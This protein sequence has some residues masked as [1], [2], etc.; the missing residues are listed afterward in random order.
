MTLLLD[1]PPGSVVSNYKQACRSSLLTRK[2]KQ[3]NKNQYNVSL[4]RQGHKVPRGGA[5]LRQEESPALTPTWSPEK[6][7]CPELG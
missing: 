4:T 7:H 2:L 5:G 1:T 6:P 3:P